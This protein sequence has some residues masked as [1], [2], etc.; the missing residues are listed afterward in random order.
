M[1]GIVLAHDSISWAANCAAL[2]STNG[3]DY[4]PDGNRP[5]TTKRKVMARGDIHNVRKANTAGLPT[6]FQPSIPAVGGNTGGVVKSFILP[7]NTTGVVRF[8]I[9]PS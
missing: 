9:A 3:E 1:P 8:L 6:N 2:D 7:G 4:Y 5:Q